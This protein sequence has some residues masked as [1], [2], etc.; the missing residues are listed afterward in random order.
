M[1]YDRDDLI[2]GINQAVRVSGNTN[3][4]LVNAIAQHVGLSGIEFECCSVLQDEGPMTSGALARRCG[5]TSGG[6]TGLVDRLEKG[7]YAHRQADPADRRRVV[8]SAVPNKD[9]ERK[10]IEL[11]QPLQQALD[12]ALDACSDE[13]LYQLLR[14]HNKMNEVMLAMTKELAHDG[15]KIK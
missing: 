7:G 13:V 9:A 8:V 11:Y 14:F 2:A 3:I 12:E 5:I 6:L 10:I 15:E 4:L 1:K